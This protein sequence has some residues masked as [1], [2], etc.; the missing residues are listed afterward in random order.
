MLKKPLLR[1][2]LMPVIVFSL[3]SEAFCGK[4]ALDNLSDSEKYEYYTRKATEY[5]KKENE[6]KKKSNYEKAEKFLPAY[7]NFLKHKLRLLYEENT[8]ALT[9]VG[10]RRLPSGNLAVPGPRWRLGVAF[11]ANWATTKARPLA[12]EQCDS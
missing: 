4:K 6:E 8:A 12:I 2:F 11:D 5:S 1:S 9:A 3:S 10:Y 7:Q